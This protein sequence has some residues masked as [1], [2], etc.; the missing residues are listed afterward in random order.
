MTAF[1]RHYE[2]HTLSELIEEIAER[3]YYT[4][5]E[6]ADAS[7]FDCIEILRELENRA[8]CE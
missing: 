6:L 8:Y 4:E 1:F 5:Q 2:D 7:W 3:T